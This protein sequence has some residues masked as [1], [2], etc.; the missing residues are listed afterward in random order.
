MRRG[1]V[2]RRFRGDFLA[3]LGLLGRFLR[4]F[5]SVGALWGLILGLLGPLGAP[6]WPKLAQDG[7]KSRFFGFDNRIW[8]PSWDQKS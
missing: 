2:M 8:V 3:H 4:Y 5:G 6:F 1:L 7:E